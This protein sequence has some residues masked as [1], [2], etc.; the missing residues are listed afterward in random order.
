[1]ALVLMGLHEFEM[2]AAPIIATFSCF[3]LPMSSNNS[4]K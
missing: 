2:A 4:R 3:V 1:M